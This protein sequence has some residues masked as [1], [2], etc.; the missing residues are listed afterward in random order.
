MMAA[1]PVEAQDNLENDYHPSADRVGRKFGYEGVK[2]LT[3][4][5]G[6]PWPDDRKR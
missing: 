5:S 4:G 3:L 1:D 2:T 6:R